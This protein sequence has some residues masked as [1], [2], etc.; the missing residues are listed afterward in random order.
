MGSRRPKGGFSLGNDEFVGIWVD[1]TYKVLGVD[2]DKIYYESQTYLLGKDVVLD[3]L[4]KNLFSQRG[5]FRVGRFD[6]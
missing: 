5:W 1:E 3:G 6:K 2:F 4:N